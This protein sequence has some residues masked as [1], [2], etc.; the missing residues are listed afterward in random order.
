MTATQQQLDRLAFVNGRMNAEPYVP[1]NPIFGE[2]PDTWKFVPDGKGWVCR[3]YTLAKAVE[4]ISEGWPKA[5]L[6]E[7]LCYDDP[8]AA[9]RLPR[10]PRG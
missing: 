8:L 3:D 2:A 1:D 4:L 9:M 10:R 6:T 5:D 7:V